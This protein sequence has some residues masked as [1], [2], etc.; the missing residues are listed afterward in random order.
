LNDDEEVDRAIG[1]RVD[2]NETKEL[3]NVLYASFELE[4]KK[5]RT[6]FFLHLR[7][8]FALIFVSS[9]INETTLKRYNY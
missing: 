5:R 3:L 8:R 2:G 1:E 6:A 7:F 9:N 4:K